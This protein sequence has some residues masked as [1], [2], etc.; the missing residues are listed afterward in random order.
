MPNIDCDEPY[1]IQKV[2]D[3]YRV[4]EDFDEAL[5]D[6]QAF[7]HSIVKPMTTTFNFEKKVIEY[8][9]NIECKD[10]GDSGPKF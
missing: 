6:L 9:R 4:T 10:F 5:R 8:D 2:Q 1:P 7:G 3:L